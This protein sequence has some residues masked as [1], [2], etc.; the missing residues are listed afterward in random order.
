[1]EQVYRHLLFNRLGREDDRFDVSALHPVEISQFDSGI[2]PSIIRLGILLLL[3]DV[4]LTWAR[5]EKAGTPISHDQ[6]PALAP[7]P[8]LSTHPLLLQYLFFLVLCLLSTLA[9]HLPIRL[10]C[11]HPPSYLRSDRQG[12]H[13]KL[14]PYYPKPTAISTAIIVSSCT[15]LFPIL[16]IVWEYDLPSAASAV[17]WAVIVNNIAAV[18]ILMDCGY[19]RAAFLVIVGAVCRAIVGWSVLSVV[20]LQEKGW[21]LDGV[22]AF[23]ESATWALQMLTKER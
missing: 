1:M 19:L 2:Q 16:L 11:S 10:L 13:I 20:G 3:F 21:R 5:I 22:G 15:K 12:H 18:E 6:Q 8:P 7:L 14:L 4:Y 9:F 17:S 23:V